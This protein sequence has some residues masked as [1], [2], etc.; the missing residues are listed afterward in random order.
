METK[1]PFAA[2]PT[3]GATSTATELDDTSSVGSNPK[4]AAF[5]NNTNATEF[6]PAEKGVAGTTG[7]DNAG[8]S[9]GRRA[10]KRGG[11]R[12]S[13]RGGSRASKRGGKRASKRGGKRSSRRGGS[14]ASRR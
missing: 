3:L 11:K 12:A 1:N 8:R 14:R 4:P 9:G 10:S 5:P 7:S 6:I 13:K 2:L